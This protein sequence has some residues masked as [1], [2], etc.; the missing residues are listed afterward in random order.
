MSKIIQIQLEPEK[1][2]NAE[3]IGSMLTKSGI[4]FSS[5][6][7]RKR[8]ID[9]RGGRV[10]YQLSVEYYALGEIPDNAAYEP[11][12]NQV[13]LQKGV[14]IVGAGPAGYFAAIEA[15]AL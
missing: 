14:L 4:S 3:I 2:F 5:F 10:R 1:A 15:I 13:A 6:V 8:S 11:I 9:A 12:G 7:V